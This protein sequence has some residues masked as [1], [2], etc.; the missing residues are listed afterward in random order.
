VESVLKSF[1]PS[2]KQIHPSNVNYAR[3]TKHTELSL[4]FMPKAV[5]K[6]LPVATIRVVPD[7]PAAPVQP[8]TAINLLY[9]C[10]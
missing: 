10:S 6:S 3:V 5:L 1:A 7:A 2:K 9:Q 4:S 8:A